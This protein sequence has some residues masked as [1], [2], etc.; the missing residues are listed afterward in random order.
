MERQQRFFTASG[1][2]TQRGDVMQAKRATYSIEEAGVLLGISRTH[3]YKMVNEGTIK[4][5]E[6][7]YRKVVPKKWIESL[8]GIE[9][10]SPEIQEKRG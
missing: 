5:L 9:N 1:G 3:T 7:G 2:Y 4:S 6:F 8:L 10:K